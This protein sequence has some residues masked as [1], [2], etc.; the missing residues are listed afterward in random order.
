[1]GYYGPEAL[2]VERKDWL[3]VIKVDR[4]GGGWDIA[5]IIDG[6]YSG[7]SLGTPEEFIEYWEKA[8]R[9]EVE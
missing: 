9:H 2:L 6:T 1:M 8:V 3:E 4:E 5:V 7:D